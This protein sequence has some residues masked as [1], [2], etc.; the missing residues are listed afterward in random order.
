[1]DMGRWP[2]G[3]VFKKACTSEGGIRF[4]FYAGN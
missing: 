4:D 3:P 1:M 2:V